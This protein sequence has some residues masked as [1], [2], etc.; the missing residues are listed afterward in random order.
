MISLKLSKD[1]KT[2]TL[3]AALL[4][5]IIT[6][7]SYIPALH[8]D[9][10]NWDDSAHVYEN[11][12]IQSIDPGFFKWIFTA[13]IIGLWLPLTM[14]SYSIDYAIWGLNPFGFHLTNVAIHALNAFLSF[15]L[16]LRLMDAT[17]A[18]EKWIRNKIFT[19]FVAA[20][21]FG[22]HPLHVE[23]VAWISERKDVLCASFYLLSILAYIS[24]ASAGSKNPKPY[25]LCL[26]SFVLALMSKP[27]A[28]SLPMVLLVLDFYPLN[29]LPKDNL[30]SLIIEKIPFF[31][32]GAASSL[33]TISFHHASSALM[34]LERYPLPSR[35]L[36]AM[37]SYIFYLAKTAFP[38]N[39]APFYPFPKR[40]EIFTLAFMSYA[41]IFVLI[42]WLFISGSK[43]NKAL[44]SLWL[45]YLFTLLP[46]IGIIKFGGLAA[47]DRYMYLPSLGPFFLVGLTAGV[48]YKRLSQKLYRLTAII[49]LVAIFGLLATRTV[50]QIALWRDSITLWSHE[51]KLYPDVPLS[52]QNRGSAYWEMGRFQDALI[53][54]NRAIK[55]DPRDAKNYQN[56]G[57]AYT[58]LRD[59][60]LAI[61]D[62]TR[63]IELDPKYTK[64]YYNRGK[65]YY[66]DGSLQMAVNDFSKAIELD[67]GYGLAYYSLGVV[68][69][70]MG[71]SELAGVYYGKAGS[72]KRKKGER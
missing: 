55:L 21:L 42:S 32:L 65:A 63:A 20:L 44:M 59:Y 31:A 52:Y 28:V 17:G 37:H 45:Y 7:L 48:I 24:Y 15:I 57:A 9:F 60:D 36:V 40:A 51:I 50:T 6:F 13:E 46:V 54:H 62:F 3:L 22:I 34:P 66:E 49:A 72:V 14:F 43:R 10:V 23:S 25:V 53:D 47:A 38:F 29:R 71:N 5:S 39:L 12:H 27:M 41:A 2:G 16:I 64:A 70:R 1:N 11:P 69:S 68:Y 4:V 26:L 67:P 61:A 33:I 56:R 35:I 18:G 19:A 58:S 8:N 30:P